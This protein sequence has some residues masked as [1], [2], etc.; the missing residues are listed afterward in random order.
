LSHRTCF[1]ITDIGYSETITPTPTTAGHKIMYIIKR[2]EDGKYVA[3]SGS[4][5]SYTTKLE[6]ARIYSTHDAAQADAC[7]NETVIDLRNAFKGW[8]KL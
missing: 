6:N 3:Q 1:V 7:G 2:N 4:K 5:S 8:D